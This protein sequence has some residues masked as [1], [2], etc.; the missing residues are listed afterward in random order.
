MQVYEPEAAVVR[1]MFQM[2]ADGQGSSRIART[3][4]EEGIPSSLAEFEGKT[5]Q[6]HAQT[7]KRMLKNEKYKGLHVWN[8]TKNQINQIEHRK[9]QVLYTHTVSQQ[10]RDANNKVVELLIPKQALNAQHLSA[11]SP[12]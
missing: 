8:K 12:Q 9:E 2:C 10:K 1:R 11:P 4:Q 7:I 5:S 6:W 3:F